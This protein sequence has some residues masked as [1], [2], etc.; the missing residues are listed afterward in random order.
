[1]HRR[2]GKMKVNGTLINYYFHCKRQCY[3]HGNRINLEDNSENVMIGRAIHEE[4]AEEKNTE[5]GLEN[6]KLDKLTKEYLT[7]VKKSDADVE[8][9]RWQLLFYLKVLKEKGIERKG[10]LEF[11]E[12]NKTDKKIVIVELGREEEANLSEYINEIELLLEGDEIPDRLD[13]PKCKKCAYYEYCY[14]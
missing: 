2:E 7:E 9:A 11:V 6:I 12:K 8:A 14:I 5:I 3:L 10:K 4:R 13:K 1:M